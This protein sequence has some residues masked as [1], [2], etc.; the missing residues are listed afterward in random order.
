MFS[1]VRLLCLK[2][3]SYLHQASSAAS[4]PEGWI[5]S[6]GLSLLQPTGGIRFSKGG[7][8]SH[9]LSFSGGR[10][11]E[12]QQHNQTR[13]RLSVVRDVFLAATVTSHHSMRDDLS[14]RTVQSLGSSLCSMIIDKI[15]VLVVYL[16]WPCPP[17]HQLDTTRSNT[18]HG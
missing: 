17:T 15:C 1:L 16:T 9:P 10:L 12:H 2:E 18:S 13:L 5:N 7:S 6:R 8:S 11:E 4:W 3:R 14:L